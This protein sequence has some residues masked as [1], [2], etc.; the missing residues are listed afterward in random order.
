[1]S[2]TMNVMKHYI[3]PT[4]IGISFILPNGWVSTLEAILNDY[5]PM[6]K[7]MIPSSQITPTVMINME[8]PLQPSLP[9]NG[10]QSPQEDSMS[11]YGDF[12]CYKS[13][14]LLVFL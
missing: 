14:R 4:L 7:C 13:C 12:C 3:F 2:T 9:L 6:A 11:C 10:Y 5:V 8:V 1:M